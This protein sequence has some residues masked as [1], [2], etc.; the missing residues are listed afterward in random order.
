MQKPTF[1][2]AAAGNVDLRKIEHVVMEIEGTVKSR[3]FFTFINAREAMPS[4]YKNSLSSC[5][6]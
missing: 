2:K 4:D 3:Q 5:S 1:T 6:L